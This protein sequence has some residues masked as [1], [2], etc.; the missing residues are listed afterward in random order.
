M[1]T[2]WPALVTILVLT[3][4]PARNQN[5][6]LKQPTSP[7]IHTT[8]PARTP[9]NTSSTA[10]PPLPPAVELGTAH[11]L[12]VQASAPDGRWVAACQARM[13]TDGDGEIA[14]HLG[15]H[16][17]T[18][19]DGL[20]LF[21]MSHKNPGGEVIDTFVSSD[22]SA[23]YAA[24][25][26]S[27]SLLLHDFYRDEIVDLSPKVE[28]DHVPTLVH[29]GAAFD[30]DGEHILYLRA[31][32]GRERVVIRELHSA[33]ERELDM[34][35]GRVWRA[36]FL[37]DGDYLGVAVVE[38]DTN[39][40]GK[41]DLPELQTSLAGGSCRGAVMSYSTGGYE[42][43]AWKWQFVRIDTGALETREVVAWDQ[44][45]VLVS[46][47][48]GLV[49]LD[50]SGELLLVP[51]DRC[52][53]DIQGVY[54]QGPS[55]LVGC[56]PAGKAPLF[57]FDRKGGHDLGIATEIDAEYRSKDWT[58]AR[59]LP[60]NGKQI[61]D[62]GTGKV[63]PRTYSG[64]QGF[65][66]NGWILE[67]TREGVTRFR[68]LSTGAITD[69]LGPAS[70]YVYGHSIGHYVALRRTPVVLI[71]MDARAVVGSLP[72]MPV[73]VREG[74]LALVTTDARGREVPQG[75]LRWVRPEPA[76]GVL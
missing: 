65:G 60:L 24:Y 42:G 63:H 21:L 4:C 25:L 5:P 40:N 27:G 38:H 46:A 58:A 41:L 17:D 68:D 33:R 29:R 49:W 59:I 72:A 50:R 61:V 6:P 66:E 37:G 70:G 3:A 7:T 75:P 13:D 64:E 11:P 34:G 19:G 32:D 18:Y 15:H 62:L 20:V 10:A 74:G 1:R 57:V 48:R 69:L 26:D 8:Q 45:G 56:G 44:S 31:R 12:L 39:K 67:T 14:V 53:P 51:K 22:P 36:M 43:D 54:A 47:P 28:Q 76:P 35:T 55:V 73:A 16:G 9:S 2:H 71:D 23:R 30:D 52:E